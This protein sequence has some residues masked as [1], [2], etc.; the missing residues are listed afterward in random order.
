MLE[1]LNLYLRK[2]IMKKHLIFAGG[3]H[4]HIHSLSNLDKFLDAGCDVTVVNKSQYHYYS[5]MGP[6]LLSGYYNVEDARF[7]IKEIVESSICR[8]IEAEVVKIIP[9]QKKIILSDNSELY[10]DVIS[11]NTG[12][13]IISLPVSGDVKNLY[14]VKPI[15]NISLIRDK[16][17]GFNKKMDIAVIGGGA[18]GVEIAANLN[19]FV[20]KKR[21]EA[22]ISLISREHLLQGYNEPFYR[23]TLNNLEHNG[24]HIYEYRNVEM[25]DS[26][27]IIFSSGEKLNYDL[28]VNAS[29]V[30][31]SM[32]FSVSGMKTD[33][34]GGLRVN[35]Y[36]QS[37]D[38]PEIFAGGDCISFEPVLNKA[39]VYAVR[40]GML[41]YRNLLS[42]IKEMELEE[43]KPQESYLSILN[44]GFNK[45]IMLWKGKVFSGALPFY[46]K[47]YLDSKFMKKYKKIHGGR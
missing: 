10:Y 5:G 41:L 18:A 21:A 9:G 36:L 3:G 19:E 34:D 26:D 42:H 2:G 25:V 39:G 24:I 44:I 22:E 20:R 11:F 27:N 31:P 46:F 30:K 29:G 35:K 38:Y 23:K 8:F 4:S 7:N 47:Y 14:P 12:S 13:E 1:L 28:A 32:I 43:F 33:E 45:G 6:G 40:E 15:E 37:M 17:A 16:V